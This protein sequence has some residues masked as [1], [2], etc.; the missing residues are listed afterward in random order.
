MANTD[1]MVNIQTTQVRSGG[2][3]SAP[4]NAVANIREAIDQPSISNYP[5][6]NYCSGCSSRI[7]DYARAEYDYPLCFG[8]RFRKIKNL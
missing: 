8:F 1:Q 2:M 5:C 7:C 4:K 3:L 6:C